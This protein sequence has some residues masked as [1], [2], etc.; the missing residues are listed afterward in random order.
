MSSGDAAAHS[1]LTRQ[2]RRNLRSRR[3]RG[4]MA[5]LDDVARIALGL[6]QVTEG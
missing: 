2:V 4:V 6:P 5:T 3:Y 1:A